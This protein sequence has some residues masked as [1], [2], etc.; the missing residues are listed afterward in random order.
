M[1]DINIYIGKN[2]IIYFKNYKYPVVYPQNNINPP[3]YSV[4]LHLMRPRSGRIF[5][6]PD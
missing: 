5:V 2:P 4:V 6:T 3:K 1:Y